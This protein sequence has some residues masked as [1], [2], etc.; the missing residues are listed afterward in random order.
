MGGLG[1]GGLNTTALCCYKCI[2]LHGSPVL[3]I[4][5]DTSV[6]R[7]NGFMGSF[8]FSKVLH[9][10]IKGSFSV[11]QHLI[12]LQMSLKEQGYARAHAPSSSG[13]KQT[14]RTHGLGSLQ[15]TNDVI[16]LSSRQQ[17]NQ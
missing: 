16:I 12:E 1:R 5:G 6:G 3:L 9:K 7:V 11:M 15:P 2:G 4:N 14:L 17:R 13:L 8:S 10:V